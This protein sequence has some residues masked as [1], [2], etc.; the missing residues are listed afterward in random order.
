MAPVFVSKAA[1]T[2]L[3]S[4]FGKGS[5]LV[6][7]LKLITPDVVIFFWAN[8]VALTKARARIRIVFFIFFDFD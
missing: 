5:K 4:A 6:V 8:I 7:A 1:T 3:F 2:V